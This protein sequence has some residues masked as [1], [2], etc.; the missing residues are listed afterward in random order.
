MLYIYI[1]PKYQNAS[2]LTEASTPIQVARMFIS[3]VQ[4]RRSATSKH[5][6]SRHQ[7]KHA[8]VVLRQMQRALVSA[9]QLIRDGMVEM[10]AL[11]H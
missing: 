1:A 11:Y 8:Y 5:Q 9:A 7:R 4:V 2:W 10:C 3:A 6:I